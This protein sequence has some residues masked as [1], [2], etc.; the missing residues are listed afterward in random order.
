MAIS[1]LSSDY[2]NR[3]LLGCGFLL[4]GPN[5][6]ALAQREVELN[7]SGGASL[8]HPAIEWQN[9]TRQFRTV[10]SFNTGAALRLVVP[11]SRRL[12]I[13]LEQ[14][15]T[16]L[17]QSARYGTRGN[18][19]SSGIGNTT[20]H[21]SGLSIRLY[22]IWRPGPR[23]GLDL[24]LTGSYARPYRGG[25]YTYEGP[26]WGGN[27]AQ[28]PRPGI[29]LVLVRETE[30]T[31]TAA[32]GT[33]LLLRYELGLRHLLLLTATYQRGLSVL[34]Q[35]TSTRL[36]YF[37][38]S[39]TVQQGSLV[40]F[41]RGSYATVQL[42]YGLRLGRLEAAMRRNPTPRYSLNPDDA[43]PDTTPETE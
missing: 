24:A 33:E 10:G 13:G 5:G 38:D 18:G 9:L 8:T 32:V 7:I 22:D 3:S 43:D 15:I 41:S 35:I 37:D 31:G 29:P 36:E 16:G 23:W 19:F 11:L 12:G 1:T 20:I 26:L 39:G 4:L 34:T 14:R 25:T 28:L 21:Q 17:S 30:R 40:I 27:P 2:V 42:G 6:S